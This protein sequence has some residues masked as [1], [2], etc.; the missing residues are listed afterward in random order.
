MSDFEN[1]FFNDLSTEIETTR[2]QIAA[3]YL[4]IDSEEVSR[5][6]LN[7]AWCFY[8]ALSIA[9]DL[10]AVTPVDRNT[11][12]SLYRLLKTVSQVRH[13]IE[14]CED[15]PSTMKVSSE[16][17]AWLN[18]LHSSVQKLS[19][20]VRYQVARIVSGH[21]AWGPSTPQA[22]VQ[23]G[24]PGMMVGQPSAHAQM[25]GH[26]FSL[27]NHRMGGLSQDFTP[28]GFSGYNHAMYS[29]Q[30]IDWVQNIDELWRAETGIAFSE[31]LSDTTCIPRDEMRSFIE[32][33]NM[34]DLRY[35][36]RFQQVDATHAP[37]PVGFS[38]TKA[39]WDKG[40][41]Q[42]PEL[43][44]LIDQF[45]PAESTSEQHALGILIKAALLARNG[46]LFGPDGRLLKSLTEGIL[47]TH[48]CTDYNIQEMIKKIPL[49][50][51]EKNYSK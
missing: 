31:L 20:S 14:A 49:T 29:S 32:A 22:A 27:T 46:R 47:D 15:Q 26:G 12:D 13:R 5:E 35:V 43:I 6:N 4:S 19:A 50:N 7:L 45:Y 40:R 9:L 30:G 44:K 11:L 1:S 25:G 36:D 37:S 16:D 41:K 33:V 42:Y 48:L 39:I 17:L 8:N 23:T 18:E 28:T 24:G 34:V 38:D 3:R 10:V 2:N 21:T 51:I